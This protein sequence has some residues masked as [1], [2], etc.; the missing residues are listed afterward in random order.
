MTFTTI[1]QVA[2]HVKELSVKYQIPMDKLLLISGGALLV[3][4]GRTSTGDVD[5]Y[6]PRDYVD[7]HDLLEGRQLFDLSNESQDWVGTGEEEDDLSFVTRRTRASSK[8]NK[9]IVAEHGLYLASLADQLYFKTCLWTKEDRSS[10]KKAQDQKDI[11]Y[12][13]HE[14]GA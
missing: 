2:K 14:C 12:L 4:G 5:I 9:P 7:D 10:E 1:E 8:K 11:D 6:I 13:V 3:L